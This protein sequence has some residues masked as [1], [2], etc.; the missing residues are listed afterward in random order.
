[1][2]K[3]ELSIALQTNKSPKDYIALAKLVNQYDFDAVS[4]YCDAPFHP[5]YAPLVLMAPHI[6]KARLGPAAISP[7]RIHP[8]DIAANTALLSELAK[9]GTYIGIARGAWLN[10]HGVTELQPPLQAIRETVE[11]VQYFLD[12]RSDGYQGQVFQIAENVRAPYPL[13]TKRIPIL[14]GTWG[15]IL[16]A[17]AGEIA[18]EVKIGGTANPDVVPIMRNY[19]EEGEKRAK[20]ER[21]SVNIV[22]GAVCVVDEDR[23]QA[24]QLARREVALYLPIVAKLDS[25]IELDPDWVSRLT[26]HVNKYEYEEA[27]RLISDDLLDRFAFSGNSS[28][29]IKQCETLFDAGVNRIE[30]GTPHGIQSN[31][32]IR[33]IGEKVLPALS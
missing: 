6:T 18:D 8:I 26:F 10:S 27:G 11:I 21:E 7:S 30:F 13:P 22:V 32:G 16:C 1:M 3:R 23:E 2:K 33:L 4:V 9:G 12:G 14:I 28:D 25:S 19:I 15:R 29:L 5:S 17:I 31:E 20:R 24:R